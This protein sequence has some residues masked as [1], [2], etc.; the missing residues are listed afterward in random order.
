MVKNIVILVLVVL[1]AG[2]GY[3]LMHKSNG[4]MVQGAERENAQQPRPSGAPNRPPI[5]GKGDKLMGSPLEKF[6]FK[7]APGDIP[8]ESQAKLTG[9]AVKSTK[10]ADGSEQVSLTPKDAD[11]Q[12]QQY[13]VKPGQV[14]YFIE[15]TGSDDVGSQ[16]LDKNYRDD[17]GMITDA[18]GVIQ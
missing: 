15:M 6:A 9:F 10:L 12:F 13:T 17:Y 5:L 16:D 7:I 8:P 3:F 2:E 18:N 4:P 1:A 11:D 14:L